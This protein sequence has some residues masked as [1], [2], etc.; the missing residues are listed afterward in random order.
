MTR[1]LAV[2]VV[3]A[4][5]SRCWREQRDMSSRRRTEPEAEKRVAALVLGVP[6]GTVTSRTRTA[7]I[8]QRAAL[9]DLSS[10]LDDHAASCRFLVGASL[11]RWE[12]SV[13]GC[14]PTRWPST[15][16]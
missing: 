5:A 16:E 7:L 8:R 11:L 6:K 12:W 3:P 10:L 1:G 2:D 13:Q 4:E 15:S 9:G 14:W